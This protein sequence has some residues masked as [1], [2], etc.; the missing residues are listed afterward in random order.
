MLKIN[1]YRN[2]MLAIILIS[3]VAIIQGADEPAIDINEI[4]KSNPF[5][6]FTP[7]Q[8]R[9]PIGAAIT[10]KPDLFVDTATLKFLDAKSVKAT[11]SSMSG[12]YGSM[13]PD[14]KGNTLIICDTNENVEKILEQIRKIDRKP[15]Q[16]MIEVVLVDVKLNNATELGIN[17]DMLTAKDQH[18]AVFRQNLGFTDRLGSTERT[19]TDTINTIGNATAFNTTGTGS[20]LWLLFGGDIRSVIHAIQQKNNV[21]ILAS[22]RVMVVSGQ[23]ASIEAV[24]EIPYSEIS[25]T[26]EGGSL[27]S[28]KFKNVGVMLNIGATLTDDKFILLNVETEQNAYTGELNAVPTVDTRK[29][30]SSLLLEDGQVLVIGG[31]RQKKTQKQTY[32][33]PILGDLPIVGLA[34]KSTKTTENNSE[35]LII[36]SPHIYDAREKLNVLEMKKFN[37]ITQ[38]PLLT[39]PEADERREKEKK[40]EA[41]KIKKEKEAKKAK[42]LSKK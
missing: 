18:E 31:L 6:Q 20:D 9:A 7:N 5:M 24:E 22:P 8:N 17:W 3:L 37:E 33:L 32:Q 27:T 38:R 34:F 10:V 29:V 42:K 19:A 25:Q 1:K 21:E 4:T 11:I 40:Q 28:T 13:E 2:L 30:V 35:L 41:E 39:I 14:S 23:T 16:V 15:D 12:E 26:S 36:L